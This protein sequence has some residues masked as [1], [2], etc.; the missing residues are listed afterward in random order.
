MVLLFVVLAMIAGPIALYVL[1][2]LCFGEHTPAQKSVAVFCRVVTALFLAA[3]VI[4]C[5]YF[6]FA[7]LFKKESPQEQ[8]Y[9][10]S[11][12]IGIDGVLDFVLEHWGESEV[13]EYIL[14]N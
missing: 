13:I 3:L 14:S 10:I 2:V 9:Q 6:F 1:W 11:E 8:L 7:D 4:S 5:T 12:E